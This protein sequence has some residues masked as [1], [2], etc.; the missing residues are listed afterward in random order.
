MTTLTKAALRVAMWWWL[1]AAVIYVGAYSWYDGFLP[2]PSQPP[3][4]EAYLAPTGPEY[5]RRTLVLHLDGRCEKFD[6][7]VRE[8]VQA[9]RGRAANGW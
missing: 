6:R 9:E 8:Q 1:P 7:A 4:L 5:C 2:W 3:R